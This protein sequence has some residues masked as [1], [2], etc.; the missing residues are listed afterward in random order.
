MT[1][2]A[3]VTAAAITANQAATALRNSIATLTNVIVDQDAIS[4][5]R[6]LSPD[7]IDILNDCDAQ[8]VILVARVSA[9]V[10]RSAV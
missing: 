4:R 9:A 8:I 1:T 5:S 3:D 7:I 2:Q 10:G 6:R